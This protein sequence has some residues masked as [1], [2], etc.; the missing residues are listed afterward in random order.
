MTEKQKRSLSLALIIR[1]LFLTFEEDEKTRLH[2]ELNAR[3][4]KALRK[5][6]KLHSE[7]AVLVIAKKEAQDIWRKTVD[8]FAA[9]DVSIEAK[10]CVLA[11]WNLDEN[12]LSKHYGLSAGKIGKWAIPTR[13]EDAAE[14]DR[15]SR[16]LAKY[17]FVAVNKLYGIEVEEK[18]SVMERIAQARR[19]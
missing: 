7:E 1:T 13:R 8:H 4:S 12:A 19:A 15:S 9:K 11:I 17:V 18:M 16:E 6:V 3:M 5:Q 10:S 14:L 2:D